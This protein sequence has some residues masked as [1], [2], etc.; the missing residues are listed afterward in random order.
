MKLVSILLPIVYSALIPRCPLLSCPDS[1]F[2]T[3]ADDWCVKIEN[4]DTQLPSSA[5]VKIRECLGE[6]KTFCEWSKPS[7]NT[8]M[9]WPFAPKV[10]S[11]TEK[12]NL[13]DNNL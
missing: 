13:F 3:D 1:D 11:G 6:T 10:L 4:I 5:T 2:A 8:N 9:A 12:L 7:A